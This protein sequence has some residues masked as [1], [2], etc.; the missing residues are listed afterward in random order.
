MKEPDFDKAD[1]RDSRDLDPGPY[2]K[3]RQ[4]VPF[5]CDELDPRLHPGSNQGPGHVLPMPA[6]EPDP[7][8]HP[9]SCQRSREILSLRAEELD[10]RLEASL[11]P[12]LELDPMEPC[13]WFCGC[14]LVHAA[15]SG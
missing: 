11:L 14:F 1:P 7:G 3:P 12:F 6:E 13:I 8:L 4:T 15:D 2:Q 10:P 5:P 9:G